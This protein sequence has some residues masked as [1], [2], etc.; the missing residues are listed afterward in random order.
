MCKE[1]GVTP[2][3][4]LLSAFQSLLARW[5]GADDLVVGTPI[6]GRGRKE[7]E[8]VVGFFVNTLILRADLSGNPDLSALLE[9]TRATALDAFAHADVP[10]ERLVDELG[11]PRDTARTP[12]IQVLFNLH[13]EPG[14]ELQMDG[15]ATGAAPIPRDTAKFDLSLS[16]REHAQGMELLLEYDRE[17]FDA[18]TMDWLLARYVALLER[19]PLQPGLRLGELDLGRQPAPALPSLPG[20]A[21]AADLGQAFLAQAGAREKSLA[22]D[23]GAARWSYGAL[24]A[25]AGQVA[26]SVAGIGAA[27]E[28]IG[29]VAPPNAAGIAG[30]LGIL[31][32]GRAYV[33]LDPAQPAA[34]LANRFCL[35][36]SGDQLRKGAALNAVQIAER[37]G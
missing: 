14:G 31:L 16:A 11:L 12:L 1:Q 3:M 13:N 7:L 23:D 4:F 9:R 15:L 18:E 8:A 33:P 34:P 20:F 5:T 35:L 22:V 36:V 30:L 28:P 25:A 29:L 17:L 24:A 26:E 2:F 10:F 32:A 19:W 37:M 27:G 21:Q 6:A